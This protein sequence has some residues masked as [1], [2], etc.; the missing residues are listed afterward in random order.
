[1]NQDIAVAADPDNLQPGE[2]QFFS[3]SRPPLRAGQYRIK[4]TQD[5]LGV[6]DNAGNDP[7]FTDI[8]NFQVSGPRFTLDPSLIQLLYPPVEAQGSF[9][10][11]LPNITL[12]RRSLPWERTID[13]QPA[14]P[15][16]QT[17]PWL[18]LLTLYPEDMAGVVPT[19]TSVERLLEPLE[20]DVLP[21]AIPASTVGI[22]EREQELL[23]IDVELTA[24]RTISPALADLPWLAHVREVNT[25][26]KE[27]LGLDE[28][29]WFSVIVGNRLP[30]PAAE[31]QV[32][33]VSLEGHGQHLHGSPP[34]PS[35]FKKIRLAMLAGWR[36]TTSAARGS[37]IGIMQALPQR[38][39]V[40]LLQPVGDYPEQP[41]GAAK[42][43]SDAVKLGYMPLVNNTRAG[44][45]TSSYYRSPLAP[46]PTVK[47]ANGPYFFSDAAIQYDPDTGLFNMAFA[48]AWQIG[49]L[50]ALA[51]AAFARALFDWRR[52]MRE[53]IRT[54]ALAEEQ[55]RA[56]LA[57]APSSLRSAALTAK[58]DA[59]TVAAFLADQLAPAL[60]RLKIPAI[61]PHQQRDGHK[62]PGLLDAAERRRI[63][64]GGEDP[65]CVL[66]EKIGCKGE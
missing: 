21:P 20:S 26:G 25:G 34:P 64:E 58:G 8:R 17:A 61:V 28:D 10:L 31:T 1:M 12:R 22:G 53:A 16:D 32:Y 57:D 14:Q 45:L 63:E 48:S 9:E 37:F 18:G 66:L 6:K 47:D 33:L 55:R 13:S 51:D 65:V 62:L 52:K 36:F 29:G 27:I 41:T 2:I 59:L 44:E 39:G 46:V 24:F 54:G 40:S 38:G 43:A 3:S 5:V 7:S 30:K 42:Q 56:L 11:S 60:E 35:Q 19:R 15:A 49:R 50:L 23:A 4:S